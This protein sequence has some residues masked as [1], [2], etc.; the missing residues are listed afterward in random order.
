MALLGISV[1]IY[2]RQNSEENQV[3]LLYTEKTV[4]ELPE[5]DNV[6]F[7][8]AGDGDVLYSTVDY[9][10][11]IETLFALGG[12]LLQISIYEE[13]FLDAVILPDQVYYLLMI[14]MVNGEEHLVVKKLEDQK[15]SILCYLDDFYVKGRD[16]CYQWK[17][18]AGREGGLVLYTAYGYREISEKGETL[19]QETW[20]DGVNYDMAV[21][22]KGVWYSFYEGGYRKLWYHD[23]MTGE[24]TEISRPRQ[25]TYLWKMYVSETEDFYLLADEGIFRY[26]DTEESFQSVLNW[27][28]YGYGTFQVVGLLQMGER[29]SCLFYGDGQYE[30]ITWIPDQFETRDIIVL[31]GV[32]IDG[33]IRNYAARYNRMQEEYLIEIRDY[34]KDYAYEDQGLGLQDLYN[35]ILAKNGPDIIAIDPE[36]M[37]YIA[38]MDKRALEDLR[39]YLEKSEV[40]NEEELIS[41]IR[42]LLTYQ[43]QIGMLPTNFY[44]SDW[45]MKRQYAEEQGSITAEIILQLLKEK[46]EEIGRGFSRSELLGIL[47]GRCDAGELLGRI[48]SGELEQALEIL[49]DYPEDGIYESNWDLYPAGKI[50]FQRYTFMGVDDYLLGKAIWGEQGVYLTEKDA[51]PIE[52]YLRNCWG[53]SSRSSHKDAAWSFIESF[54]TEEWMKEVTPNWAF[55]VNADY[56]Q[57]QLAQALAVK[58]FVDSS[59]YMEA[60][61]I[62][63]VTREDIEWLHDLVYNVRELA[64]GSNRLLKIIE[65]EAGSYY[66]GDKTVEEVSAVIR[67]R[68]NLYQEEQQ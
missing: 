36:N 43:E 68:V 56:F 27:S 57:D 38:L 61:S 16:D 66:A 48:D 28:D 2:H 17:I 11:G 39:P 49:K 31:G 37:D 60:G 55:S 15:E 63:E 42:E 53:I 67:N 21:T 24:E 52:I 34:G 7:L 9:E 18:T 41:S 35:A 30:I 23:W 46:Q 44:I 32:G 20:Q 29:V 40:I 1:F 10:E 26:D 14:A 33:S 6:F 25:E 13:E 62:A 5:K 50:V 47:Y 64:G 3:M 58:M 45:M 8:K 59:P 65:E 22:D 4:L 51:F 54:F 12:E 19:C